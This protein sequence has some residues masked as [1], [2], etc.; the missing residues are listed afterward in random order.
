MPPSQFN[1]ATKSK[2]A[3]ASGLGLCL[4]AARDLRG[5]QQGR[6]C[7]DVDPRCAASEADL[8]VYLHRCNCRG[9]RMVALPKRDFFSA[10]E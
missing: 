8:I 5:R 4:F 2:D 9:P 10:E 1:H 3:F 6:V 7:L